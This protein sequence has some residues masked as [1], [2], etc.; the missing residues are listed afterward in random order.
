MDKKIAQKLLDETRFSKKR[1]DKL[2]NIDRAAIEL[3]SQKGF[4]NTSSKEIAELAQ[5]AEGTIFRHYKT[6]ENLLVHILVRFINVLVPI[7]SNELIK[8][9]SGQ[10]FE[11]MDQFIE[12]FIQNRLKFVKKNVNMFRVFIKEV[13][14]NDALRYKLLYEYSKDVQN[15]FYN[16]F[17]SFRQ[18]GILKDISNSEMLERILKTVLTEFIWVF[19]LTEEYKQMNEEEWTKELVNQFIK[20]L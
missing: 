3:F 10:N 9:V 5:V 17:D 18:K 11:S 1:T 4:A 13:F 20:G 7:Y 19:A 16:L 12:F 15:L 2:E 8:D 6:K 14:Y